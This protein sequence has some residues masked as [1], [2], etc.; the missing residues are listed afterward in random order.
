MLL[1]YAKHSAWQVEGWVFEPQLRH[2][3]VI[4]RGNESSTAK[5]Y[6]VGVSVT[7]TRR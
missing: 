5:R 6:A 7:G 1:F 3:L 2:T 4:K